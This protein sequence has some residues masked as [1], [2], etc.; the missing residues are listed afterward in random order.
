MGIECA[1]K[2]DNPMSMPAVNNGAA[3]Y[4][5]GHASPTRGELFKFDGKG[6]VYKRISDGGVVPEGTKCAVI[7]P[8]TQV[9]WVKFQGKGKPPERKGGAIFDGFVPASRESL[10]DT[11][12]ATWDRD[13]NGRPQDPWVL[14]I[15]LPMQVVD[16]E[17]LLIFV[18]SSMTSR[19]EADALIAQ[20]ERMRRTEPNDYPVIKL[21]ISGFNH[22]DPR[23]GFI[24]TPSL[25]RI[26]KT[27]MSSATA[28]L[29][30]LRDDMNDELPP[31]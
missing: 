30:S 15:M 7:Y 23:V 25:P 1:S 5:S 3:A 4:L 26:G 27:P 16:T 2:G 8:K 20:C 13:M 19:S 9:M 22:K 11:D 17:E 24:K 29:S 14:Q 12:E 10:G 31:F 28:V 21:A 6:G 18:A